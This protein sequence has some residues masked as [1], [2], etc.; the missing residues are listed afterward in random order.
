MSA[1]S[2]PINAPRGI[3]PQMIDRNTLL[4]RPISARGMCRW[5]NEMLATVPAATAAASTK[6]AAWATT[7]DEVAATT[8]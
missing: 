8:R 7:T 1:R 3:A 2:P 5:R 6:K 4:T